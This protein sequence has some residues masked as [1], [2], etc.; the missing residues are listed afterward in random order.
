[1]STVTVLLVGVDPH[2]VDKAEVR[3]TES[4][5]RAFDPGRTARIF[6]SVGRRSSGARTG[7]VSCGTEVRR[8]WLLLCHVMV[9]LLGLVMVRRARPDHACDLLFGAVRLQ[10]RVGEGIGGVAKRTVTVAA[11]SGISRIG[12]VAILWRPTAGA[13]CGGNGYTRRVSGASQA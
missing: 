13:R 9:Q 11:I 1:M 2:S 8:P 7:C 6:S 10:R 3:D 5:L 4:E 12:D